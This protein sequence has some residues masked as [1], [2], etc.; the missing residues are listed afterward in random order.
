MT[1]PSST[2]FSR[3]VPAIGARIVTSRRR[4]CASCTLVWA[5]M[6]AAWALANSRVLL[7]CSWAEITPKSKSFFE[8]SACAS[9]MSM[10]ARA[11]SISAFA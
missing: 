5:F 6:S 10:R 3:I 4:S 1:W 2:F 11:T 7:S 8:R 9:A